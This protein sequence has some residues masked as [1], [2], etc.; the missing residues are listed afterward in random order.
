[1]NVIG[2]D[3]AMGY[4]ASPTPAA[5]YNLPNVLA[6]YGGWTTPIYLQSVN[7]TSATLTWAPF[8]GGASV[9]QT[10]NFTPGQTTRID[11][12]ASVPQGKQYAVTVSGNSTLAAIVMEL[13]AAGGDNAMIYGGFPAP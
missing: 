9:T 10:V 8:T 2:P 1:V 7:A 3:S 13:H 11:P 4:S 12:N 5:I 6:S